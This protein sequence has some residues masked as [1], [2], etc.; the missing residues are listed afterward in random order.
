MGEQLITLPGGGWIAVTP[1]RTPAPDLQDY[2]LL[3][4]VGACGSGALP[5]RTTRI[6]G[7]DR[8]R[9]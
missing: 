5:L 6:P 7:R 1:W 8:T 3:T 2:T 9:R 4:Q